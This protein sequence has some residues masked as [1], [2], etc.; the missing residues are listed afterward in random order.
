MTNYQSVKDRI[1]SYAVWVSVLHKGDKPMIR[2]CINDHADV[3]GK[4]ENLTEYQK[5]L[6]ANYVC[7]LHPK[8]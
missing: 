7:K 6:L 1:R 2:Q 3:L 4:E 8:D 5:N